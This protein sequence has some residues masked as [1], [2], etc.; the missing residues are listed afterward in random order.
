MARNEPLSRRERAR[1]KPK[2][3][4][5][6]YKRWFVIFM[7]LFIVFLFVFESLITIFR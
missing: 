2:E 7:A 1:P 3:E 4:K 5:R 6:N